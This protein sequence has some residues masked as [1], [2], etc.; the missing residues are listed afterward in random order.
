MLIVEHVGEHLHVAVRCFGR[1]SWWNRL[2]STVKL[3]A[4]TLAQRSRCLLPIYSH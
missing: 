2:F 3:R 4:A 1:R